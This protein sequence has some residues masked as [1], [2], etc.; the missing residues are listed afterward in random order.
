GATNA[1]AMLVTRRDLVLDDISSLAGCKIAVPQFYNT[2]DIILRD[3]LASAGLS[4][5]VYGGDVEI[6]ASENANT[7]LLLDKGDIDAAFVPEPWGT[8]LVNEIGAN[9]LLDYDE[10]YGGDYPSS[11]VVVSTRF[12]EKHPEIVE[13]FVNEHIRI[14]EYINAN[15]N[16][17]IPVINAQ[18]EE[19]SGSRIDDKLIEKAFDSLI[20][21]HTISQDS[22]DAI[23]NACKSTGYIQK[24]AD[25]SRILLYTQYSTQP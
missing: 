19:L 15:K 12:L 21:T 10:I 23:I 22:I 24:D 17:V 13:K 6:I 16:E 20:I 14:T 9:I 3:I 25:A 18:I 1:G 7:K 2:Q 4:D 5:A 8:R 11:L